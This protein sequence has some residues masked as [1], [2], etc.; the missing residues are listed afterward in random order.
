M[1]E[2][3]MFRILTEPEANII[4][5]QKS[6]LNTE[7]VDLRFTEESLREISRIAAEANRTVENIGTK[8]G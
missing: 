8:R 7:G 5:Q 3:D 1:T 6:L 4:L 2:E